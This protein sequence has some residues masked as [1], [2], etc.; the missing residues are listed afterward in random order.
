MGRKLTELRKGTK[1]YQ[2]R[3]DE[4]ERRL[5]EIE[6]GNWKDPEWRRTHL[7]K[8]AAAPKEDKQ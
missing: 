3:V 6:E 1:E 2:N 4:I 5:R 7:G 8:I